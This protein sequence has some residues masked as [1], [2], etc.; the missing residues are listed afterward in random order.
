MGRAARRPSLPP[1]SSC[2]LPAPRGWQP[3]SGTFFGVTP[4]PKPFI[5][6]QLL[7]NLSSDPLARRSLRL[8]RAQVVACLAPASHFR[9]SSPSIYVTQ[10]HGGRERA[11]RSR[12]IGRGRARQRGRA[13]HRKAAAE[14]QRDRKVE[15]QRDRE[16]HSERRYILARVS[17]G[18][19]SCS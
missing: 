11:E 19:G 3:C 8:Q 10:K 2:H 12:E 4:S 17:T 13:R 18:S 7:S 1:R 5:I 16:S 9:S 14:S 6:A 15:R